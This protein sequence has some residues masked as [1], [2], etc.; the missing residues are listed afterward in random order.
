MYKSR[1]KKQLIRLAKDGKYWYNVI[2]SNTFI[3]KALQ[4]IKDPPLIK[5]NRWDPCLIKEGII[6]RKLTSVLYAYFKSIETAETKYLVLKYCDIS[7]QCMLDYSANVIN[8]L[9]W[10]SYNLAVKAI[11]EAYDKITA[12]C[13]GAFTTELKNHFFHT[14]DERLTLPKTFITSKLTLSYTVLMSQKHNSKEFHLDGPDSKPS[15][16]TTLTINIRANLILVTTFMIED[17][18]AINPNYNP[19][20]QY[21]SGNH[22]MKKH[23]GR[24]PFQL[25]FPLMGYRNSIATEPNTEGEICN[26]IPT[27]IIMSDDFVYIKGIRGLWN[28]NEVHK[29][30]NMYEIGLLKHVEEEA[31]MDSDLAG[32]FNEETKEERKGG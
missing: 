21:G 24:F 22:T 16:T 17:Y 13:R 25:I 11:S 5:Y 18:I 10:G 14:S 7:E 26:I 31:R 1:K 6:T 19:P 27:D 15:K 12:K 20:V 4:N 2:L 8:L 28:S 9:S 23:I 32:E 30:K 29:G 3:K